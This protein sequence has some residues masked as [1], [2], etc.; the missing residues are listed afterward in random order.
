ME[1][2]PLKNQPNRIIEPGHDPRRADMIRKTI[3]ECSALKE[4]KIIECRLC[5]R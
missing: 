5:G 4:P 1:F 2:T 3:A